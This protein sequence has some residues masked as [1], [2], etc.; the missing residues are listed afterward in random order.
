MILLLYGNGLRIDEVL[1]LTMQDV[2]LSER[3]II[4]RDTKFF[5]A[6][7]YRSA[8]GYLH[9]YDSVVE[10]RR[11]LGSYLDFFNRFR[12]HSS[13]DRKTPDMVYFDTPY[14]LQA[15]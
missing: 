8:H 14:Q 10:A 12:P 1:R 9:A 4:V 11:K 2:D 15:A 3:V 7:W 13:L 6:V 5:K